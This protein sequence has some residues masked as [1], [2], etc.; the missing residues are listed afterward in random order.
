MIKISGYGEVKSKVFSGGEVHVN[1]PR[2][3]VLSCLDSVDAIA[4]LKSSEDIMELLMVVSSLKHS[5]FEL[6]ELYLPYVPYARQD[7]VCAGGDAFGLKVFAG[8]INNLGFNSVVVDDPH[9]DMVFGL[10]ENCIVHEQHTLLKDYVPKGDIICAPDGGS[11]KK[12]FKLAQTL[13]TELITAEKVR[14]T[15]TGNILT[16][17]VHCDTLAGKEVTIVDDICDGG[18]TFIKLAEALYEKGAEEV[19]LVVTHG[20]FSKGKQ[21]LHNAGIKQVSAYHDWTEDF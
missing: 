12:A 4:I 13:G 11:L 19:S 8:L 14:C 7:R 20:I 3:G 1:I 15:S 9:S 10:I 18:M 5:G 6:A 21:V 16:T 17:K 2:V